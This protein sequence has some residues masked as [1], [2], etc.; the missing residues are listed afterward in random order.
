MA[1]TKDYPTYKNSQFH[2]NMCSVAESVVSSSGYTR[3]NPRF[4][5]GQVEHLQF[6][7]LFLLLCE[8]NETTAKTSMLILGKVS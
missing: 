2:E 6:T 4:V 8:L 3:Y 7:V 5:S 1:G